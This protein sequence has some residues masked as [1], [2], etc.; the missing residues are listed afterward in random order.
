MTDVAA[1]DDLRLRIT[2]LGCRPLCP[3]MVP[4]TAL[5]SQSQAI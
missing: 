5:L 3:M 2:I 1:V 4:Y